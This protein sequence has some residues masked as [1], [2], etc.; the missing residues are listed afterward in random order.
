MSYPL[1]YLVDRFRPARRGSDIPLVLTNPR[2][3]GQA[4][5]RHALFGTL[6]GRLD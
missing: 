6:L 4:A 5:W 2:G 3:F 1:R